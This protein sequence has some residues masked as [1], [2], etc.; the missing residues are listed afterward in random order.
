MAGNQHIADPR[1]TLF[2]AYYLNPDSETF[3]N[4]LQSAL[5]AGYEHEYAKTIT[6]QMPDWLSE[7]INQVKMLHQAEKNLDKF[8]NLHTAYEGTE[9]ENAELLRIQADVTKFVAERIGRKKYG[10]EA[11][12]RNIAVSV[13]I[14]VPLDKIYGEPRDS[15][16]R[17]MPDNS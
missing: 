14:N 8:L 10:K 6:A 13:N 12:E 9:I 11:P 15:R 1:Q 17:E 2:L 7:S 16:I 3:S 4:G 5:R